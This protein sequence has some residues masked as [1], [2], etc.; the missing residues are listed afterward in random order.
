MRIGKSTI[1]ALAMDDRQVVCAVVEA[2]GAVRS[3]KRV[4][5]FVSSEPILDRPEANGQLLRAFLDDHQI[6]DRDG[7]VG[8][9]ARWVIGQEKELPPADM[10]SATAMLRLHAERMSTADAGTLVVDVAGEIATGGAKVLLVGML[11]PQLDKI[12]KLFEA[13]KLNVRA[14]CP[15]SLAFSSLIESDHVLLATS[16]GASEMVHWAAGAARLLRP[17]SATEPQQVGIELNR[18]IT[19][20]G[21]GGTVRACG[22]ENAPHAMGVNARSVST[23]D[24]SAQLDPAALNGDAGALTDSDY[25]PAVALAIVGTNVDRLPVNFVDSRLAPERQHRFGRPVILAAGAVLAVIVGLVVLWMTVQSREQEEAA[26]FAQLELMKKDITS[27][28]TRLDRFR[29]GRAFF[30]HRTGYMDCL[31]Q[32]TLAF[33]YDEPI[34][35]T[36]ITLRDRGDGTLAGKSTEQR[37]VLALRD[38]LMNDASFANVQL[39]DMRESTGRG[40]EITY[41]I[42]FIYKPSEVRK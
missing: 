40:G 30:E 36:S 4:A 41:S 27:A 2:K 28:E 13:A 24:L 3:V 21:L 39:L 17:M 12:A 32:L 7:I 25:L 37:L 15:T 33:N 16:P 19:M 18:M 10:A 26:L 22:V 8:V 5:R 42:N 31:R 9:P 14:I 1:L 38:R 34:W 35:A 6:H 20:R 11:R 23:A 29:F